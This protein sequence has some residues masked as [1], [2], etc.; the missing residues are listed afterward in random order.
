MIL[1][2]TFFLSPFFF[3]ESFK[4]SQLALIA[5]IFKFNGGGNFHRLTKYQRFVGM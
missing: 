1:K 2:S 3:F 4:D 5:E